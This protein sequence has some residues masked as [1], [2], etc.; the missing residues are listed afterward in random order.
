MTNETGIYNEV[1]TV[2]SINDVENIGQ[3]YTKNLNL[4]TFLHYMQVSCSLSRPGRSTLASGRWKKKLGAV[5]MLDMLLFTEGEPLTL[6]AAGPWVCHCMS[7]VP[8]LTV[9]SP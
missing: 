2:Y 7:P 6:P 8:S 4:A 1:R 3:I 5:G 9:G